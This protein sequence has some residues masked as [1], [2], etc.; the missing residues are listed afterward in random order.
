MN[1]K[2]LKT[3]TIE[4]NDYIH[5]KGY[6]EKIPDKTRYESYESLTGGFLDELE[7]KE[8]KFKE[9][10]EY[11]EREEEKIKKVII[12]DVL[13]SIRLKKDLREVE[14]KIKKILADKSKEI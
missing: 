7:E 4:Y 14:K 2:P 6:H 1:F 10:K 9:T 11:K 8:R 5:Q 13:M 12:D 3:Y